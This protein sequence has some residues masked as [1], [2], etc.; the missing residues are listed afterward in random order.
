M[1]GFL[2][3]VSCFSQAE[4]DSQRP[5]AHWVLALRGSLVPGEA[6][7]V[8]AGE[9]G[10]LDDCRLDAFMACVKQWTAVWASTEA[11]PAEPEQSHRPSLDRALRGCDGADTAC[12]EKVE[13]H[14]SQRYRLCNYLKGQFTHINKTQ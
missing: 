1:E 2:P 14:F 13:R 12:P 3:H 8:W 5:T 6:V 7:G 4:A 11:D 9:R 10:Q